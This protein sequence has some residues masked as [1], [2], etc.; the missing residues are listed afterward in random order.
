[1]ADSTEATVEAPGSSSTPESSSVPESS[2][3][4]ESCSAPEI[5]PA[6]VKRS[7]GDEVDEEFTIDQL[8][9][10]ESKD[11]DEPEDSN[12]KAVLLSPNLI[13]IHAHNL[14]LLEIRGFCV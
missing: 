9:I 5:K 2:A 12:I 8:S 6:E 14:I 7:W 1:M 4:S 3:A 10:K 11:L 13:L